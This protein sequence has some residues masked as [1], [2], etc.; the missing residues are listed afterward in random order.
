[1]GQKQLQNGFTDS[2]D[3]LGSGSDNQIAFSRI[4]TGNNEFCPAAI[5][6][7]YNAK[8]AAPIGFQFFMVTEC[9]YGYAGTL[10]GLQ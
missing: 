3:F 9:G 1:M 5:F 4:D 8:P 2:I 6:H 7:F 10:G